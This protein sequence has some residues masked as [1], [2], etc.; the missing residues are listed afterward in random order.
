VAV[1]YDECRATI[2]TPAASA[3]GVRVKLQNIGMV[4]T[5]LG[6][7]GRFHWQGHNVSAQLLLDFCRD[8]TKY[9]FPAVE[10]LALSTRSNQPGVLLAS[11]RLHEVA[12]LSLL[13]VQPEW[14]DAFAEAFNSISAQQ[15]AS[16]IVFG[17]ERCVPP[18]LVPKARKHI[19]R[20]SEYQVQP[21]PG[22]LHP[23]IKRDDIAIIGMSCK[24]PGAEGLQE[25]WDLLCKGQSQHREVPKD[26]F[27]FESP[28]RTTDPNRKWFGNFI[29][30]YDSFD[31]RFFKK[32]P[33]EASS[34]D[35]Q[36]R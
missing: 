3:E 12:I 23:P 32:S 16:I 7:Q 33:R 13:T 10:D 9:H 22:N 8:Q 15:D 20:A 6:F 1:K 27:D 28:F 34:T 26:R 21:L 18:S 14:P 19:R 30:D 36:Q 24:V 29:D 5:E 17:P 35:P 11:Q 2:T 4:T 31:H 25:F